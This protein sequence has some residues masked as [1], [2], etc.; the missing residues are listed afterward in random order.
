MDAVVFWFS[1]ICI[2]YAYFGYP[3]LLLLISLA[4]RRP[5]LKDKI[6]P[7]VTMII[8][9]RN[10]EKIIGRKIE[11]LLALD[12]PIDKLEIIIVSDCSTDDSDEII[13]R[14][15]GRGVKLLRMEQRMGKHFA[16]K[17]AID[18][19]KGEII[20]FTDASPML[21]TDALANMM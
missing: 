7:S 18:H 15:E 1:L 12:Y 19:A 17:K 8:A 10:E 20:A 5:V 14:Y 2:F 16:Q 6:S 3:L 11:N 9:A 4:I 13:R 21:K